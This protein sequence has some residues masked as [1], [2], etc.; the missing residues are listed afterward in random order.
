[1]TKSIIKYTVALLMALQPSV[2]FA[3]GTTTTTGNSSKGVETSGSSQ[4]G[5]SVKQGADQT[6]S[7]NKGAAGQQAMAGAMMFAMSAAA[8]AAQQYGTAAMLAGLGILSMLQSG[9]HGKTAGAAGLTGYQ[10]N[11]YGDSPY[12][13]GSGINDPNNPINKD[14]SVKA[15]GSNIK[16]LQDAGILDAKLGKI[17]TPDGKSYKPSDF[18]SEGAMAAAGFSSGAIAGAVATYE[19]IQKRAAAK[20]EKMKL[21]ALTAASGYEEGGGGGGAGA[22]VGSS[23]ES[24]AGV[25]AG[26]PAVAPIGIDRDPSS[27]AGMQKNYNGE[28]IGVAAD[29]IFLMMTRRYKVKESQE[30]FY[31]DAELALQK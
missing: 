30:S 25:A 31:T 24:G 21:G 17:T 26:G 9:Q 23:D 15:M 4:N 12:D 16:K 20:A 18:A 8:A 14:P 10:S 27:L 29:S 2:L 22:G 3:A 5:A 28:P 11:G 7:A 6:A 1:M 19:E 13:Y